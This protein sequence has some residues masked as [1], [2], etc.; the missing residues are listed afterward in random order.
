MCLIQDYTKPN[1]GGVDHH[2][3]VFV[4]L[5]RRPFFPRALVVDE[6][7][8]HASGVIDLALVLGDVTRGEITHLGY[9]VAMSKSARLQ[10][11]LVQYTHDSNCKQVQY[12]HITSSSL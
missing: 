12:T 9:D 1:L 5:L 2:N 3:G 6:M 8:V 11:A 4:T 10:S 7:F